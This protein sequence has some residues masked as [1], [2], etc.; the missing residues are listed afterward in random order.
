MCVCVCVCLSVC[1]GEEVHSA[2]QTIHADGLTKSQWHWSHESDERF[3]QS[4]SLQGDHP[5]LP[6]VGLLPVKLD[7]LAQSLRVKLG[8]VRLQ[9][10][11]VCV[12]VCVEGGYKI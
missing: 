7:H 9:S 11:C 5:L 2:S 4:Q 12:C 1:V 10:E 8:G 3:S 6:L